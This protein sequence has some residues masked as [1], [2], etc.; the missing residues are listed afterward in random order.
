MPA[1]PKGHQVTKSLLTL[2]MCVLLGAAG[3]LFLKTGVTNAS[4]ALGA[5]SLSLPLMARSP[6]TVFLNP[7]V[8][9]GFACYGL[10]SVLWLVLMSRYPLSLIYPMIALGYV[11][12]TLGSIVFFK[13]RPNAFVWLA[14]LLIV[15]G[16]SLL[17]RA[18]SAR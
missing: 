7:F 15:S 1:N 18:G 5:A 11:F 6:A 8:L 12:V 2:L 3:Q 17:A 10:S 14:L 16:V 9:V 4:A 13:D